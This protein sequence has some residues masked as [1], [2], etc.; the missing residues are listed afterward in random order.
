VTS[1]AGGSPRRPARGRPPSKND[2]AT[3]APN[4]VAVGRINSL[5]G[6]NGF[7]KVTPLTSN[8]ERLQPGSVVLVRG[9]P[10]RI[11]EVVA[12]QGYPII[13]FEGYPD[14][15]SAERLRGTLIEID[16]TDLPPLAEDEYYVDD[17]VGLDVVTQDGDVVGRLAEVLG[18]GANDVYV[19]TREGKK[20]ALVPVIDGV[21]LTVDLEARR[22][23]IDPVPGLLD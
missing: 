10:T 8:P 5:W 16:E 3:S 11:I 17:L 9:R 21:V 15:T 7:V 18:T 6:L 19:V 22:V 2:P 4:R 1:P 14:R 13:R 23:V 12:P 20:D